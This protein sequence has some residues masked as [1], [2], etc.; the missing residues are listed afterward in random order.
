[1]FPG[2]NSWGSCIRR[3]SVKCED[4]FYAHF[5]RKN[6]YFLEN[7]RTFL[8]KYICAQGPTWFHLTYAL[9]TFREDTQNIG[10]NLTN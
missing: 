9:L 1:M 8:A 4:L 7:F 2:S 6:A 10:N 3:P 5:R